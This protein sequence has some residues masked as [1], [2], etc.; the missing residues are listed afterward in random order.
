VIQGYP[1][2]HDACTICFD[3]GD[4]LRLDR[5]YQEFT[6][7]AGSSNGRRDKSHPY[8]EVMR[9]NLDINYLQTF[10]FLVLRQFFDPGPL[11]AEMDRILKDAFSS[12][13]EV[14]RFGGIHFEYVPMMTAD[15]PESLS[16]L[17]RTAVVAEQILGGAVIPTRAK[18]IRYFGS[19]PW[20]VDSVQPVTSIG[21]MAYLE[22]LRADNGALRVIPGS[23]LPERGN[24]I[25]AM[26][27][28][29]MAASELPSEILPTEPGDMIVF[30]E[31]LFH[32]SEGGLA[33]RQWR[34]DY[35]CDPV[36]T[37][38][39]NSARAYYS[40]IYAANWSGGYDVDRYPS[41]GPDWR[42]SARPAVRRLEALGVYEMA[43]KHET[44]ARLIHQASRRADQNL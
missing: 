14:S 15:T 36:D 38:T 24:V 34:I 13:T 21:F 22:P 41:Y 8:S 18:A 37:A 4:P 31:H 12:S 10:G 25:R 29:G 30:D 19:T 27:G 26:G 33:R 3:S 2:A 5:P 20:H 42:A 43:A 9:N 16:L 17:D 35:L 7:I 40:S 6:S 32:S 44:F 1:V 28:T 11:S 39:R 23:H